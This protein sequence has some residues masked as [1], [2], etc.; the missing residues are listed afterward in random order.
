MCYGG[1][2][3]INGNKVAE[4]DKNFNHQYKQTTRKKIKVSFTVTSFSY[5]YFICQVKKDGVIV[6]TE[7]YRDRYVAFKTKDFEF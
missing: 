1:E 3:S 6:H 4:G 2:L 7:E 5:T